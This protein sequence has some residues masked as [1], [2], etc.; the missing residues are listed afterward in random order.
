MK[1]SL[2]LVALSTIIIFQSCNQDKID[3]LSQEKEEYRNQAEDRDSTINQMLKTF[4]KIQENLNEIKEREGVL[5]ISNPEDEA[6]SIVRDIEAINQLMKENEALNQELN[7]KIR[8]S[9]LKM[10][11][12]RRKGSEDRIYN[13]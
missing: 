12:F 4:N 7:R 11:E 3:Q 8:N 13:R 6:N 1:K 5:V 2:Y 10:A 9:D